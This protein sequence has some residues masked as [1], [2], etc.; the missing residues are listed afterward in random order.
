MQGQ[1]ERR[2][3]AEGGF[4][5]CA[6]STGGEGGRAVRDTFP[7][8]TEHAQSHVPSSWDDSAAQ[9]THCWL[10]AILEGSGPEEVWREAEQ[11]VAGSD[12][13]YPEQF[14]EGVAHSMLFLLLHTA[15]EELE[16]LGE[17]QRQGDV[18]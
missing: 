12:H 6:P 3:L 14:A 4:V 18:P 10:A 9:G 1:L 8:A 2:E 13:H 11:V 15:P 16:A 17:I 7:A 5:G